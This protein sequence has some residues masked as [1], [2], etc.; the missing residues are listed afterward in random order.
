MGL[1][2]SQLH[3]KYYYKEI[4]VDLVVLYMT[5]SGSETES[6]TGAA[7]LERSWGLNLERHDGRYFS[8]L[9]MFMSCLYL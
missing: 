6:E 4:A 5:G 1:G 8:C 3:R 9:F 7:G 2:G